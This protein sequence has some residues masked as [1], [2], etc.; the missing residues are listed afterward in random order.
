M[1]TINSRSLGDDLG[2]QFNGLLVDVRGKLIVHNNN[3]I[4][5]IFDMKTS[6]PKQKKS[7][8]KVK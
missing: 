8:I 4:D 5:F 6:V 3:F 7:K 2:F 1:L